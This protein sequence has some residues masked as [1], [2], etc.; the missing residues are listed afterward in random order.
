LQSYSHMEHKDSYDKIDLNRIL[1]AIQKRM[2]FLKAGMY[3]D[4]QR[5]RHEQYLEKDKELEDLYIIEN[6]TL[7]MLK[8]FNDY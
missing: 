6:K 3:Q 2:D 5:C 1:I 4:R 7:K 8:T